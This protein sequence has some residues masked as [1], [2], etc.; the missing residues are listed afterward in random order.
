NGYVGG[1]NYREYALIKLYGENEVKDEYA[2]NSITMKKNIN[3]IS[4]DVWKESNRRGIEC[5]V[6]IE[7]KGNCIITATEN[8][9]IE[10]ENTTTIKDMP[11]KIYAAITG[12]QVALTDIRFRRTEA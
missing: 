10:I 1:K 2:Q 9:G 8:L 6:H 4:W 11:E 5:E 12:D 7:R 3:F